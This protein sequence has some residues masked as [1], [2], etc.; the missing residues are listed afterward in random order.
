MKIVFVRHSEPNYEPCY[1]RGF[2]GHG[3]DLAPLTTQG[4]E[5]AIVVSK[6]QLLDNCELIIS[7]P[8]TRALQ[9]AA[10]I[11]KEKQLNISVEIDL[12]EFLPDKTFQ[13]KGQDESDELHKDF[14]INCGAYPLGETKKW[15]TIA[16]IKKRAN[17][18][19]QKYF[20]YDRVIVVAH[21]GIIRRFTG[22]AVADYCTPYEVEY[23]KTF[24]CFDWI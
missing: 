13:Y 23:T 15:E 9:T 24:V 6:N 5:Q 1:E 16:E 7:S 18:V 8:Y 2:I 4:I 22:N 21:G 3:R 11:S 10:I 14:L 12:H 20:E 17:A 19:M